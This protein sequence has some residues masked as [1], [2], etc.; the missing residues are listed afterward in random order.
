MNMQI[1]DNQRVTFL[2][3]LIQNVTVIVDRYKSVNP[4]GITLFYKD[5][6]VPSLCLLLII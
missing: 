6:Y 4:F 3:Q 2:S 1:A 5:D